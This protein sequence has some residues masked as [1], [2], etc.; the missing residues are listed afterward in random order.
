MTF[1]ATKILSALLL[2][3]CYC[4]AHSQ[5]KPASD[6]K[7]SEPS[8]NQAQPIVVYAISPKKSDQETADDKAKAGRDQAIKNRELALT[9]V[10]A[11]AT[12]VQAFIGILQWF[13][14]RNQL[15]TTMPLVV[16]DWENMIHLSPPVR[17][18]VAREMVHHFHWGARNIG[19]TPAFITAT[20]ARFVLIPQGKGI[21]KMAYAPPEP[22]IEEPLLTKDTFNEDGL[23]LWAKIE[24]SRPFE[25]IEEAIRTKKETLYAFGYVRFRDRYGKRHESTFCLRYYPQPR[26]DH[27]GDG[28]GFAGI[29]QNK[30]T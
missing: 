12:I 18:I 23:I 30:Y 16:I 19:S 4:P 28:F 10:M 17:E 21:P 15:K 2:A 9:L 1:S 3:C 11:I 27:T 29:K 14:Y 13:I 26:F 5:A 6:H 20:S 25:Q 24:D 8:A 7:T 22:F